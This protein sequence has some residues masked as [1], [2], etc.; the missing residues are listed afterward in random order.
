[1]QKVTSSWFFLSAVNY[2]AR[3]TTHQIYSQLMLHREA[4]AVCSQIH[5]KHILN[6]KAG[7]TWS[8]LQAF[9]GINPLQLRTWNIPRIQTRLT[10]CY[11]TL[12]ADPVCSE[13]RQECL[14]QLQPRLKALSQDADPTEHRHPATA[15]RR[16]ADFTYHLASKYLTCISQLWDTPGRVFEPLTMQKVKVLCIRV[17]II[18]N[19]KT[20]AW[21]LGEDAFW[22]KIL[23]VHAMEANT[24]RRGT[25]P[26]ILNPRTRW[27]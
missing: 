9:K 14:W 1:M 8:T 22:D 10:V 5:T 4:I 23:P 6:V 2:D 3:S 26:P 16:P 24:G 7:A 21:R 12:T 19:G 15:D 11:T 20:T 18:A 13:L 17:T 27:R 25:A